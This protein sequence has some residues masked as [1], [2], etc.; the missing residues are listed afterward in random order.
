MGPTSSRCTSGGNEGGGGGWAYHGYPSL[1]DIIKFELERVASVVLG[2]EDEL[3]IGLVEGDAG[4][5]VEVLG[6]GGEG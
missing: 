3:L 5:G 2:L 4:V 6:I 1:Q